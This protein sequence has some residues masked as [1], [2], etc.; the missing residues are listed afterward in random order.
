MDR[1]YFG[2]YDCADRNYCVA[3]SAG[4]LLGQT[5]IRVEACRRHCGCNCARAELVLARSAAEECRTCKC[6]EAFFDEA[7]DIEVR[8]R[9]ARVVSCLQVALHV[10]PNHIT[11]EIH[12][13]A[14][15]AVADV[16]VLVGVGNHGNFGD[17][18]LPA[19][20][21]ETDTVNGDGAF[22][23]DVAPNFSGTSTPNHQFSPS[24]VRCVTRPMVSTW[25]R[26]KCPPNSF[27]AVS[28]CSRLTRAPF[29]SSPPFAP[30]EVLWIVSA[31]K[32]AETRPLWRS[33]IVRQ[34]PFTAMLFETASDGATEGAWIVTRPL[35]TVSS[36]DSM[37]PW[38][39]II[40]V[41]MVNATTLAPECTV[42]RAEDRKH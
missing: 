9:M 27:P 31:D 10:F 21:S 33:T 42:F 2:L 18:V 14:G 19:G 25:P 17:V 15:L 35:S 7:S 4:R 24:G 11:F 8:F 1:K 41:N 23:H 22:W 32:S 3:C 20:H 16:G 28:G 29:F 36:S 38:C 34:Q 26:T 12:R 13:V 37:T 5:R 6:L 39:S 40:P 30:N